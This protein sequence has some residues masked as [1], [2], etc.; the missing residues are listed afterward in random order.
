MK[1]SSGEYLDSCDLPLRKRCRD[2]LIEMGDPAE[3]IVKVAARDPG[4]NCDGDPAAR[5]SALTMGSVGIGV[6]ASSIISFSCGR[7]PTCDRTRAT[8]TKIV[9]RRRFQPAETILPRVRESQKMTARFFARTYT[10]PL[11]LQRRGGL[12]PHRRATG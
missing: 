2:H 9:A 6:A 8:L 1:A 7:A 11:D 4:A 5:S 12:R 10:L 3:T